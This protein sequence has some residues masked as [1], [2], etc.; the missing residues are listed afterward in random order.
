M[1]LIPARGIAACL[2]PQE[3]LL[4]QLP[5][6]HWSVMGERTRKGKGKVEKEGRKPIK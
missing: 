2:F 5:A 1:Y 6:S 4:Q 3:S